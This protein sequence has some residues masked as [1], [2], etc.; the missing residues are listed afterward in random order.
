MPG[1]FTLME[2]VRNQAQ[3]PGS[4]TFA[5]S[6]PERG[7]IRK[8]R[9]SRPGLSPA[10]SG[11]PSRPS[12]FRSSP[13]R[14][15]RSRSLPDSGFSTKPPLPRNRARR[16]DLH[17]RFRR[18]GGVRRESGRGARGRPPVLRPKFPG[19][20]HEEQREHE[21]A[22][23]YS[24][25]FF[26]D[27]SSSTHRSIL[28]RWIGGWQCRRRARDGRTF[29][30]PPNDDDEKRARRVA[31]PRAPYASRPRLRG[32]TICDHAISLGFV[33]AGPFL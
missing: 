8:L 21:I 26:H 20:T 25:G 31:W 33:L 1:T 6:P 17:H 28:T 24:E 9:W 18:R 30:W 29:A 5:C 19:K 12:V 11:V 3:S 10:S 32:G 7:L 23:Q 22:A 2:S 14:P 27:Q 13:A 16:E 15:P 4:G